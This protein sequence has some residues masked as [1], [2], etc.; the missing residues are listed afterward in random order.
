MSNNQDRWAQW[1]LHRRH[2]GDQDYLQTILEYLYPVR[3]QVLQNAAL[4]EGNTLLDVGCGDGLI[5]F[6]ALQQR[7]NCHVIF[8]DISHDLLGHI[9]SLAAELNQIDRCS[10]IQADAQNLSQ[11]PN[12]HVHVVT[13][14]SVLIYVDEKQKAFNE[15]FRVLK[16]GGRLSI[17]EPINS[18]QLDEGFWTY[19]M[20]PIKTIAA[21]ILDFYHT[22][23]PPN[24]DPMLNFDECDLV[25]FAEKAGFQTVNLDLHIKV[26]TRQSELKWETYLNTARNPKLPTLAEAIQ[27][28]LSPAEAEGFTAYLRPLVESQKATFRS[29]LAYLRAVK[30]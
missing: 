1:L 5:G 6:G 3:D 20:A 14:R 16:P 28:V 25:K 7:P 10:F 23:Q 29:A 8:S 13:T 21:K 2:G 27:Q 24:S 15:F 4:T 26:E 11:I 18:Y 22:I 30:L 17:F 12:Q 9:R 19:D